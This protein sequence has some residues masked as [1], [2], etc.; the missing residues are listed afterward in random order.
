MLSFSIRF[1]KL[2]QCE[3]FYLDQAYWAQKQCRT[4]SFPIIEQQ[5]AYADAIKAHHAARDLAVQVQDVP[6][7]RLILSEFGVMF[8]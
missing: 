7:I 3:A 4:H 8:Q 2:I 6:E 5:E 1:S